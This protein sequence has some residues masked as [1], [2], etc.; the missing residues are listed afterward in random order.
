MKAYLLGIS[1]F[2][3]FSAIGIS[4][5]VSQ[6]MKYPES[7][8]VEQIDEFWGTQVADPFRWLEGNATTNEDVQSWVAAQKRIDLQLPRRSSLSKRDRVSTD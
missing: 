5:G 8:K 3:A 1:F 7:M 4:T 2:L 6:E